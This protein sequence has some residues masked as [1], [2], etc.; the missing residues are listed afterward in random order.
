MKR[1]ALAIAA[2][3][4]W[5]APEAHACSCR[6]TTGPS[7][8]LTN[9]GE[10]VGAAAG[11]FA[12]QATGA[13]DHRGGYH[14]YGGTVRDRA[15]GVSLAV[16]G[17]PLDATELSLSAEAS[18]GSFVA[19]SERRD[20]LLLSDLTLRLRHELI[21]TP[22]H[23]PHA[24]AL[25]APGG[26]VRAPTATAASGSAAGA[27]PSSPGLGA[28][29]ISALADLRVRLGTPLVEG[30]ISGEAA[31]RTA[32]RATGI[33]RR[34][35]PRGLGRVAVF[36]YP[37]PPW[38]FGAH[39]DLALEGD[40]RYEGRLAR[41]SGQ[42]LFSAGAWA[43]RDALSGWR[44]SAFVIGGLPVAGK[45]AVVSTVVGVSLAAAR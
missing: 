35:G 43:S 4:S 13:F 38:S 42:R 29:E 40:V 1:A 36:A 2:W 11:V 14:P 45:N 6:G 31:A 24:I 8:A 34:L 44:A 18:R 39:V 16:G 37:R 21:A 30:G 27:S 9:R 26:G 32:D 19:G 22:P 23:L 15:V 10:R 5:A 33:E 20:Q 41:D 12:R 25:L 17:R 3:L 7:S 28:W